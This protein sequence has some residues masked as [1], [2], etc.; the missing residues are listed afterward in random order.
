M[1]VRKAVIPAAGVG[2]RFLPASKV[3]PKNLIPVVD[4]PM[5]QYAVEE[6]ASAGIE[7]ICLVISK[8]MEAMADHFRPD[9]E[10]REL[11]VSQ[12]KDDLLEK[13]KATESLPDVTTVY[14]DE[15]LGLGHAVGTARD[16]VG[17]EPFA[18]LL[19]DEL[20]DPASSLLADMV[21]SYERTSTSIVA[22]FEVAREE[23]SP[24]GVIDTED[25]SADPIVVKGVVEKPA[26]E[27]APSNLVLTGRYVLAP[28]TFGHLDALTPGAGGELQL[29]DALGD[30]AS[31]GALH[32]TIYEGRKWDVG[33]PEGLLRATVDLGEEH[34]ELG[35]AFS[36]FLE[37]RR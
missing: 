11:L 7:E 2:T 26:P 23:V 37:E 24:Y 30:L 22:V 12:G 15:P 13:L 25:P 31:D 4:K 9:P 19:P 10:L 36:R 35:E 8:G 33:K 3:V 34:P 5:L 27:E 28:E 29:T 21:A 18:C 32:A 17:D 6:L 16:F 1:S 20:F 14:Q